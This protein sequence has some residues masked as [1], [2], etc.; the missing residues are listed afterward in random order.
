MATGLVLKPGDHIYT[1][2]LG[3]LYEHHGKYAQLPIMIYSFQ[4]L[5]RFF[6]PVKTF[7]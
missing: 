7:D 2:C 5:L 1:K 6:A 3:G 4:L